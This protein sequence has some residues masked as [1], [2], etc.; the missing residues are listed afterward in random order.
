MTDTDI[1]MFRGGSDFR[2]DFRKCGSIRSILTKTP[3][4][5]LSATV[6][7]RTL[8]DVAE[9]L[10]IRL[11]DVTIVA[12]PP[13]RPNVF[14]GIRKASAIS[15]DLIWLADML[16]NRQR[17]CPKTIVFARSINDVSEIYGWLASHLQQLA[18]VGGCRLVSM[19]HGHISRDLL[20]YTLAEFRKPDSTIR[21][22]VSTVAFG[23]GVEIADVRQVIHW[24]KLSSVMT[25][26]QEV[27]RGGRDG[28]PARATWYV[29]SAVG[30][31]VH[32]QEVFGRLKS[33][34]MC[35]RRVLL[36]SFVVDGMDTSSLDELSRR[37]QCDR[38]SRCVSDQCDCVLCVCCTYCRQ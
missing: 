11:T 3:C 13:D 21:V 19:F 9:V 4:L 27:G 32:D 33:A 5:G 12:Y 17:Q 36:D 34:S 10:H 1:C 16:Q 2:P 20:E 25:Y 18:F 28:Q 6:N 24:G 38:P 29:K 26:W 8:C 14:L 23:M 22:I 30:G 15:V 31:D 35:L 7:Q 37:Q